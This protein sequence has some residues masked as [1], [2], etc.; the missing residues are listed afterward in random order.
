MSSRVET[1]AIESVAEALRGR[2]SWR[3]EAIPHKKPFQGIS[4]AKNAEYLGPQNTGSAYLGPQNA[5]SAYLGPQNAGSAY[6]GPQSS[7]LQPSGRHRRGRTLWRGASYKT[8][9]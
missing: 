2:T 6:L 4:D 7:G 3:G 1:G 5:G 9:R 8:S